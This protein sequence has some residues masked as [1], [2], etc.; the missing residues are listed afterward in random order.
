[1]ESNS[2][3]TDPLIALSQLYPTLS[4]PELKQVEVNLT[5][6]LEIALEIYQE[7]AASAGPVDTFEPAPTIRERSN[8]SNQY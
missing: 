2:L 7:L 4:E 8:S 3:P 5:R 1:M 6:Y